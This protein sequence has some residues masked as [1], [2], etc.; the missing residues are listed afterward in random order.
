MN[1]NIDLMPAKCRAVLQRRARVRIWVGVYTSSAALLISAF[2][3]FT[4]GRQAQL[5]ELTELNNLVELNWSRDHEVQGLMDTLETLEGDIKRYNRLAW[6]LQ[7]SD[8]LQCVS[9]MV[10]D[11]ATLTS[12]AVVPQLNHSR[13]GQ[14]GTT[15]EPRELLALEIEGV[16]SRDTVVAQLVKKIESDTLFQSV[17]LD[18]ARPTEIDG[19][20]AR[21][22]RITATIDLNATYRFF[23]QKSPRMTAVDGENGQ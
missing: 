15:S 12:L 2:A 21:R 1:A 11:A 6:P 19:I 20:E 22:F 7:V 14:G 13:R 3:T 23:D 16:A 9:S 8:V 18:F 17:T 10:P 5:R 4:A